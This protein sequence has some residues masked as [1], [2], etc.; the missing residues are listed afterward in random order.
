MGG[1]FKPPS[2]QALKKPTQIRVNKEK[3]KWKIVNIVV[4][5]DQNIKV[6]QL[7]KIIKYH[8]VILQV[9]KLW[10]VKT[11]VISVVVG[12]LGTVTEKLE[13]YLKTI[14]IP[15]VISCLQKVAL[16]GTSFILRRI[17]AISLGMSDS[18][19]QMS[20]HFSRHVVLI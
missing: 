5:G 11:T 4:R 13:N 16:L 19:Y 10:N 7:Q 3:R 8:D 1:N 2:K 20:K 14:G 9:Q 12:A 17:L 6:K 18:N 15:I